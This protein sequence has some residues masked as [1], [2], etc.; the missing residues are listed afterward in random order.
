MTPGFTHNITDMA[1]FCGSQVRNSA[2]PI[3]WTC[4]VAVSGVSIQQI[5]N[6]TTT[7]VVT[8]PII[9]VFHPEYLLQTSSFA[10]L[11]ALQRGISPLL[12]LLVLLASPCS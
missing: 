8:P 12:L 10:K 3:I 5:I 1:R 2:A 11:P 9:A 6:T 4:A 7:E